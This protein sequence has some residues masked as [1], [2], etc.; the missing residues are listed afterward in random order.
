MVLDIMGWYE[1]T[2]S[3]HIGY[4]YRNCLSILTGAKTE[5]CQDKKA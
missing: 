5:K 1:A 3:M 2:R 4:D